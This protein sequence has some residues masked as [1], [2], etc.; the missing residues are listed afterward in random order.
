[1]P[2]LFDG[3]DRS[4][5]ALSI[6]VKTAAGEVV[7]DWRRSIVNHDIRQDT[8][9]QSAMQLASRSAVARRISSMRQPVFSV[10]KN[11]SIFQRR[12]YQTSF[13]TASAGNGKVSGQLPDNRG[14]PFGRVFLF[15]KNNTQLLF[16]VFFLFSHRWTNCHLCMLD[17]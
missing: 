12:E 4:R 7:E 11:V 10:L 1:M 8:T 9:Q 14:T 2:C 6:S 17:R 5:R 3:I 13:C 15:C 16:W